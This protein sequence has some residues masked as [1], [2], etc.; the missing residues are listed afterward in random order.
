MHRLEREEF[1]K[2]RFLALWAMLGFQA[3]FI[4]SF[5]FLSCQRYVSHVT[6]FGT[7]VGVALAEGR[8]WFA[9]E[10]FGAPLFFICGSSLSSFLTLV[11]IERGRKPHYHWVAALMPVFLIVIAVMGQQGV[12]GPFGEKML[13]LR[14]FILLF[15]LSL[16]CGLQ[17]GCF[18]TL[19]KGQIRTTHLTGISTDIGTDLAR[20]WF[21][22]QDVK[23]R[24]LMK[25][26]NISRI[27]TFAAFTG[28]AV[29]STWIDEQMGYLALLIPAGT[30]SIAWWVIDRIRRRPSL[31]SAPTA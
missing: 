24:E 21:G 28:G 22:K 15:S 26:A 14:D 20:T 23:E 12:F 18:T 31:T 29:L 5:G 16:I 13:Q 30:A 17:N 3:G 7:Q 25:R 9:I 4:N 27:T 10:M 19:T 1:L 8:H 11:Q 6:G 2:S